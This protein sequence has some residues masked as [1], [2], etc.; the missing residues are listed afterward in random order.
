MSR[1]DFSAQ[2]KYAAASS[3]DRGGPG[4]GMIDF[5]MPEQGAATQVWASVSPDLAGLGSLYLEDCA[6]STNVAPYARD[7]ER[8]ARLWE[9]SE[10]LVSEG[11]RR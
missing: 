7:E 3:A 9:L 11:S 4:A 8:A 10:S 2:R 1:E 5:T 6:V